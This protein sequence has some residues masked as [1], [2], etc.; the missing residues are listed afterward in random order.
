MRP[1]KAPLLLALGLLAL[2]AGC[3][4]GSASTSSTTST[5]ATA[6]VSA[7]KPRPQ[8]RPKQK[9]SGKPQGAKSQRAGDSVLTDPKP[10]PNQGTAAVAPGVPTVRGGDDS[11]QTY[12]LEAQSAD[13]V[14]AAR[15]VEAY[16]GAQAAGRWA[17]A[18]AD[19]SA[20]IREK[21]DLAAKGAPNIHVSG[22][23]GALAALLSKTPRATRR[24]A[25]QI[26]VLSLRVKGAQ[27]FVIYRDGEGK[28]YNLLLRREGAEWK[29]GSLT[30]I[31]LVL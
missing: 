20:V 31:E 9:N 3:G 1:A 30:G 21:L 28:P 5:G 19:L 14:R 24:R 15:L 23:P 25:A 2:L 6:Q 29:I 22:C 8:R 4:G 18:C 16:L 11:I 7:A 10:L 26:Q 12:G 27:A 13:R 17:S